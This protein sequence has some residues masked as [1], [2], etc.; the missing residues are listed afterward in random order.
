MQAGTAVPRHTGLITLARS[1]RLMSS[2]GLV[3]LC[4]VFHTVR[5]KVVGENANLAV[6]GITLAVLDS[7]AGVISNTRLNCHP[8]QVAFMRGKLFADVLQEVGHGLR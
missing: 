7:E 1:D 4:G 2:R 8:A 6:S 5:V 3:M